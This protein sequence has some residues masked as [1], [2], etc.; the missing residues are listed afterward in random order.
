MNLFVMEWKL[1]TTH[2]LSFV[3]TFA[4]E[5]FAALLLSQRHAV[6]AAVLGRS[7]NSPGARSRTRTAHSVAGTPRTPLREQTV[8]H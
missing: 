4:F 6:L 7:Q 5:A 2:R 8:N 3:E 1:L